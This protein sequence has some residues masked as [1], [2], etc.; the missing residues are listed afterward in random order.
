MSS[1]YSEYPYEPLETGCFRVLEL[2]SVEEAKAVFS[3]V[4]DR[5]P[6]L[7][8]Q[9]T[10]VRFD[11]PPD[12]DAL[13]YV[14][15]NPKATDRI[16]LRDGGEIKMLGVAASL[17]K[18]LRTIRH[19]QNPRVMWIDAICINQKDLAERSSEVQHMHRI[20]SQAACVRAWID[21][22][23]DPMDAAVRRLP[24]LSPDHVTRFEKADTGMSPIVHVDPDE[25]SDDD[26]IGDRAAAWQSLADLCE[27]KYW[28]RVWI[29]QEIYNA[30]ALVIHCGSSTAISGEDFAEFLRQLNARSST[31]P[32]KQAF[33]NPRAWAGFMT[34]IG[35]MEANHSL[36]YSKAN[37][38]KAAWRRDEA[39][40]K[41]VSKRDL[42]DALV[43]A[44]HWLEATDPRDYFYG[45]L[46]LIDDYVHGRL[47]IRVDYHLT[48]AQVYTEA[49]DTLIRNYHSLR[50]LT[51][52]DLGSSRKDRDI[53][54]WVP[55]WSLGVHH[56]PLSDGKPL[57]C[58]GLIWNR[59]TMSYLPSISPCRRVL[60]VTGIQVGK[61]L[62]IYND[63]V[64]DSNWQHETPAKALTKMFRQLEDIARKGSEIQRESSYEPRPVEWSTYASKPDAELLAILRAIVAFECW[65]KHHYVLEGIY[66]VIESMKDVIDV[67]LDEDDTIE[68]MPTTA[69]GGIIA[70]GSDLSMKRMMKSLHRATGSR[71]GGDATLRTVLGWV[72]A[73]PGAKNRLINR[74]CDATWGRRLFISGE[75]LMGLAPEGAAAGDELWFLP[76]CEVP[77]LLRPREGR[78]VV[79][80][81]AHVNDYLFAGAGPVVDEA[82]AKA[83]ALV[84]ESTFRRI[85]LV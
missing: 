36:F 32:E 82:Y 74:V 13:S 40:P 70:S 69:H 14:W 54:S 25:D 59:Q 11:K 20:Y 51:A 67:L 2:F 12:Y 47:D 45:I 7:Y 83:C 24:L 42:F 75:G 43:F 28:G 3:F 33:S 1:E 38:A 37:K 27:D 72:T 66:E 34:P 46:S 63:V 49:V 68:P 18:A 17:A 21:I 79:V 78:F 41:T 35:A 16:L 48:L 4:M 22:N 8:G 77:V 64:I 5:S 60:S 80:G 39:V 52:A 50:F 62:Q 29:Q 26:G 81:E 85:S 56:I 15:G 61:I 58:G 55:D 9:L 73:V 31:A 76:G 71:D 6:P 53:P 84:E 57:S 10:H 19:D 65:A 23:L 44:K 30:R